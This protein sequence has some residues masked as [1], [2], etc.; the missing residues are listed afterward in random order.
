MRPS[1]VSLQNTHVEETL[2]HPCPA[3]ALASAP[4][5]R[6]VERVHRADEDVAQELL[7]DG[8][9]LVEVVDAHAD[10]GLGARD[11]LQGVE[12]LERLVRPPVGD[13]ERETG[14]S[15]LGRSVAPRFLDE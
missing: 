12:G 5:V 10:V 13:R 7:D 14:S 8:V 3:L 11:E 1:R 2:N 15:S 6:D 4:F 9:A